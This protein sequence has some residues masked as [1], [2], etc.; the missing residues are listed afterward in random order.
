MNDDQFLA[1]LN[2]EYVWIF[3][4]NERAADAW[5]NAIE[6]ITSGRVC[7]DREGAM[8][9]VKNNQSEDKEN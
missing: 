8:F 9:Y 2:K 7:F 5:A 3:E 6:K 1:W 4:V